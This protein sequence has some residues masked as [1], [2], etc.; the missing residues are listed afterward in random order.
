MIKKKGHSIWKWF[1]EI[2]AYKYHAYH[3]L[4]VPI[5]EQ[6]YIVNIAI[7]KT[8][9]VSEPWIIIT[10][11]DPKRAIKDYGYRFGGIESVFKNQKLSQH[12]DNFCY[13]NFFKIPTFYDKSLF[14]ME[15]L[16]I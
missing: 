10:N 8:I 4:N 15:L 1:D 2:F 16:S 11:G 9:D 5:T 14:Y 3:L 13:T 12:W 7:S 6:K